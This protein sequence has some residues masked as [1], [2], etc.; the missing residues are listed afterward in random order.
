MPKIPESKIEEVRQ[1]ADIVDVVSDY[2]TLKRSG[3]NY[4][5]LCP[6]HTEKTPSFS[7]NPAKQIFYCFGCGAGGNVFSFIMRIENIS[8]P[9]AVLYLARKYHI[10]IPLEKE[11]SEES[12]LKTAIYDAN[13][14]AAEFFHNNLLK[15]PS[16][17][18]ARDYLKQR[19]FSQGMIEKFNLGWSPE[20]WDG[21]IQG[22][23]KRG[24]SEKILKAAGLIV[25]N[26]RGSAYD[27]FRGRLMFP[28]YQIS[29]VV[30]GFGGRIL[31]KDAKTAK[32]LNTSDTPVFQKGR[33]LYGLYQNREAIRKEDQVILVEGYAD[34]ISL[35]QFGIENVVASSGTA[36]TENQ[37]NLMMRMTRNVVLLYDGDLAG[38]H[39][40]L[41]G[42]DTLVKA[43]L[44]VSVVAL[45]PE[46]DPDSYVREFG[47][48]KMKNLIKTAQDLIDFKI[49]AYNSEKSLDIPQNKTELLYQLAGTIG[50]ISDEVLRNLYGQRV[51][52][53]LNLPERIVF[54]E[55]SR[56]Q[57]QE[58]APA[59]TSLTKI[60]DNVSKSASF[61]AERD[62][63]RIAVEHPEMLPF[64]FQNI[65][66]DEFTD[67]GFRR[68]FQII[69]KH[70]QRNEDIE[71]QEIFDSVEDPNLQA[72]LA[73]Y[74]FEETEEISEKD[75]RL[76]AEDC[77][78]TIKLAEIRRQIGEVRQAMRQAQMGGGSDV[79]VL[80]QKYL[81]LKQK[82]MAI[83]QH[84]FFEKE[85]DTETD[86]VPF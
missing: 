75:L 7:V 33:V 58:K 51:A 16:A 82:E 32:Y 43:G 65:L 85:E 27:R 44:R 19:G 78:A 50:K 86:D 39:A 67:P 59:E 81:E 60:G 64:I 20:S 21:L 37:A 84:Q 69:F 46:H 72:L 12:R 11:D 54:R 42:V 23:K 22:A 63:I 10:S 74:N 76:W 68:I 79:T 31:E 77:V 24:I 73:K 13:R 17:Q 57:R 53:K 61:L 80:N 25:V 62:L 48:E 55:I 38:A 70:Y 5:G 9:E 47:A 83:R 56:S 1:A 49:F 29:G 41:R 2:V 14:F 40:A 35:V 4:F 15:T 45:P 6:F 28:I 71:V 36:L 52:A 34:L 18:K 66:L 3:Q 26:E 8:F 30:V